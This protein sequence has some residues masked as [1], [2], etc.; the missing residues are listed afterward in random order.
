MKRLGFLF[1]CL[2]M[3]IAGQAKVI[4]VD[5]DGPADFNNIQAAINDAN[6]G[7][8]VVVADGIYT[9]SGNRDIEFLGKAITVW[10]QNGPEN[11]VIDCQGTET[12][13]HRGFVFQ[14]DEGPNSIISGLTIRNGYA[15]Q[16]GGIYCKGYSSPTINHCVISGSRAHCGGGICTEEGG[17]C[18]PTIK[19]C[20]IVGNLAYAGQL[21]FEPG[22]GGGIFLSGHPGEMWGTKCSPCYPKIINCTIAYNSAYSRGG[23]ICSLFGCDVT[24][25]NSIVWD[26]TAS[27]DNNIGIW[28]VCDVCNPINRISYSN[29]KG[30]LYGIEVYYY[31]VWGPGNIDTDP[32]FADPS[33]GDYHLKSQAGRYDANIGQWT[34]DEVTS[35]CI[36]AGD[37]HSPIGLEPFPN[38]GIINMSAYGGTAEASKSYFGEPLCETIIAGDINGDCKVDFRDFALMS[39]HWLEDNSD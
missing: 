1:I 32:R 20:R 35:P 2:V 9:G 22:C 30:G 23:G 11:C 12:E 19:N 27:K 29:V 25:I 13:Y 8:T 18:S 3:P 26:N 24:I 16:G 4:T 33:S 39:F 17:H 31:V 10:S 7:D 21:P 14:N 15:S 37:P 6:V 36:D 38:G 34:K 28:L 5:D